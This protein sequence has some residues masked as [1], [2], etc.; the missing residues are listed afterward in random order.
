MKILFISSS[1]PPNYDSQTIRNIHFIKGLNRHSVVVDTLTVAKSAYL[2]DKDF[3]ETTNVNYIT[4]S[5]CLL[6]FLESIK[7]KSL[8][9]LFH[10]IFNYVIAPDLYVFWPKVI[11]NKYLGEFK[12]ANYD[13]IISTSGTYL[14]HVVARELHD[15]LNVPYICDLGDPWA[16]NP[17]W[18]ENMYHKRKINEVLERYAIDKSVLLTT[19]NDNTSSLY[20]DKYPSKRVVSIPM[21]F[22]YRDVQLSTMVNSNMISLCY[23]GVAYKKSRNLSYLI[24]AVSS[25]KQCGLNITGPHSSSFD[26]LV[27]NK[28]IDNVSIRSRVSYQESEKIIDESDV[29]V[30]IGNTGGLQIPGKLYSLLGVP[31]PIFFLLQESEDPALKVMKG[32]PGIVVVKNELASLIEGLHYLI[33]NYQQLVKDSIERAVSDRVRSFDWQV[34]ADDFALSVKNAIEK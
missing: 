30:A 2:D 21:G 25:F 26:R 8:K 24:E 3:L 6:K 12:K 28:Q 7:F 23:V 22:N 16:D 5:P 34:I 20:R 9:Y 32:M 15:E 18:P 10:N 13:A 29:S 14:A 33:D 19:T 4:E 27:L 31:K 17:I 1:L 11:I